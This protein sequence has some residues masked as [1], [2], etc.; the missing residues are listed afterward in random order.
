VEHDLELMADHSDSLV[1]RLERRPGQ[2]EERW[3]QLLAEGAG[4]ATGEANPR[5]SDTVLAPPGE[6]GDPLGGR[7]A[8]APLAAGRV[9]DL[10][11]EVGGLRSEVEA[12][13]SE[14]AQLRSSLGG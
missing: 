12:L 10:E 14:L 13:R 3:M 4:P 1:E 11:D 5:G 6:A 8:P 2:K 7:G 9:A